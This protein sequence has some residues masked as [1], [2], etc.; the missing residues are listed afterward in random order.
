MNDWNREHIWRH[1]SLYTPAQI[2]DSTLG[3]PFDPT[4]YLDYL[5]AKCKDVYG[6]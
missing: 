4:Y 2:L 6:I 5:E 3:A 1:G